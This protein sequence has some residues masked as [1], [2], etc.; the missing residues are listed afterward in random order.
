M[1]QSPFDMGRVILL[2]AFA[3]VFLD[4][5]TIYQSDLHNMAAS[6]IELSW[7]EPTWTMILCAF[8]SISKHMARKNL[9]AK[10][11][12][13]QTLSSNFHR[14]KVNLPSHCIHNGPF[15]C[16]FYSPCPLS[17]VIVLNANNLKTICCSYARNSNFFFGLLGID[18]KVKTRTLRGMLH[19]T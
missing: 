4:F 1:H 15:I 10:K 6:A 17:F 14:L 19:D 3:F 2:P 12:S 11:V 16:Q 9:L 8:I 7:T 5:P 18:K 13:Q